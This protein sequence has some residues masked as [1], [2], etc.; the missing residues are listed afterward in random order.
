MNHERQPYHYEAHEDMEAIKELTGIVRAL[1]S[2][3][4]TNS[5]VR[6][7]LG[8]NNEYCNQSHL[9]KNQRAI[10]SYA[11]R[12]LPKSPADFISVNVVTEAGY[13]DWF[14][15]K[16][17]TEPEDNSSIVYFAENGNHLVQ[18]NQANPHKVYNI[19]GSSLV[20]FVE[21]LKEFKAVSPDDTI[22]RATCFNLDE[23][24]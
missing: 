10:T 6:Y 5:Q 14:T 22:N 2:Q 7:M 21:K 9:G 24:A 15:I 20:F 3:G 8:E 11:Q 18:H 19:Y 16:F 12:E 23:D 1:I 13:P 4:A 17:L